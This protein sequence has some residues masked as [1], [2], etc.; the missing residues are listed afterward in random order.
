MAHQ[1]SA[2]RPIDVGDK[3]RF[4]GTVFTI[5]EFLLGKGR[6]SCDGIRFTDEPETDEM[7]DEISVDLIL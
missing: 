3:V 1:D 5:A 7:P 4:R 2:G 6:F